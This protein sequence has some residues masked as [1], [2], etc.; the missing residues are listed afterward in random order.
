MRSD[1]APLVIVTAAK[2][3]SVAARVERR[4]TNGRSAMSPKP[5]PSVV[6]TKK[7]VTS[8]PRIRAD[9]VTSTARAG[10]ILKTRNNKNVLTFFSRTRLFTRV[11]S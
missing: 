6:S 8:G 2:S 11:R 1:T 4:K 10:T 7:A 9:S 5:P 3:H